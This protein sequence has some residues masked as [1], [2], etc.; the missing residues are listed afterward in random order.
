MR[1]YCSSLRLSVR[2]TFFA[3]DQTLCE[4]HVG[5]RGEGLINPKPLHL[6]QYVVPHLVK[7]YVC[8]YGLYCSPIHIYFTLFQVVANNLWGWAGSLCLKA[9][10][11]SRLSLV[12]LLLG[13]KNLVIAFVLAFWHW[14][15]FPQTFS[16]LGSL[17]SSRLGRLDMFQRT[18][19]FKS[20]PNYFSHYQLHGH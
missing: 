4:L 16:F 12:Y 18:L 2:T 3:L 9:S 19:R 1:C 13:L 10:I 15:T 7:G 5:W 20:H 8:G 11:T 6:L 14:Y 17:E